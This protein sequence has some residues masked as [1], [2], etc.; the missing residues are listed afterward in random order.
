[1]NLLQGI[2]FQSVPIRFVEDGHMSLTEGTVTFTCRGPQDHGH[3]SPVREEKAIW[4]T[5]SMGGCWT[6]NEG[7]ACAMYHFHHRPTYIWWNFCIAIVTLATS[8]SQRLLILVFYQFK[9][10]VNEN[11][12]L[13]WTRLMR[14]SLPYFGVKL[15]RVCLKVTY[16]LPKVTHN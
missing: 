14:T 13:F 3:G 1:M 4:W 6:L 15:S 2:H 11:F 9:I 7:H 8:Q 10:S 5:D 16:R 12:F